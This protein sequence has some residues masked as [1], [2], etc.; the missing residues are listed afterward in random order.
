L[1]R[2]QDVITISAGGIIETSVAILH[3]CP[4]IVELWMFTWNE[5]LLWLVTTAMAGRA[6]EATFKKGMR[7][8][9]REGEG[10]GRRGDIGKRE[11]LER[12]R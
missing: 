5:M 2:E 11:G 8:E 4:L 10:E 1:A 7:V 12:E 3:R 6:K 9:V